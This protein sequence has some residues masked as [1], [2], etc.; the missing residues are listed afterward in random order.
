MYCGFALLTLSNSSFAMTSLMIHLKLRWIEPPS[1]G[2]LFVS[3]SINNRCK[4]F[5]LQLTLYWRRYRWRLNSI[6]AE[7]ILQACM[8]IEV[9]TEA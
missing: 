4:G 5:Q 8:P 1:Y 9:N 3:Q 6:K 7:P 2:W